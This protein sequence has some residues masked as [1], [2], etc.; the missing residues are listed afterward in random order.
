MAARHDPHLG[1]ELAGGEDNHQVAAVV[2]GDGEH[3][4][5]IGNVG[6]QQQ[7][8]IG[9]VAVQVQ[10]MGEVFA[11]GLELFFVAVDGDELAAGGHQLM[12]HVAPNSAE[13]AEDVMALELLDGFFHAS[14][15]QAVVKIAFEEER[16]QAGEQK[17]HGAEAGEG[18]QPGEQ[19]LAEVVEGN[20]LTIT[21]GGDGDQGHVQR[22]GPG[23]L[24][25]GH[26]VEAEGA[27]HGHE[28][29][30]G[31]CRVDPLQDPRQLGVAHGQVVLGAAPTG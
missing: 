26:A 9:G 8:V 5:G 10:Q 7:V 14:S 24:L 11:L 4:G 13:A 21:D 17:G 18:D 2:A 25:V 23:R 3:P 6:G 30:Q 15:P 16:R 12:G 28:Q 20:D 29:Q 22:V 27:E 31:N 1:I 19:A